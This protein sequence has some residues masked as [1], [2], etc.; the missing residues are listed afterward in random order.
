MKMQPL[1]LTVHARL[2]PCRQAVAAAPG[3]GIPHVPELAEPLHP[4]APVR[5]LLGHPPFGAL[6]A[7]LLTTTGVPKCSLPSAARPALPSHHHPKDDSYE[8]LAAFHHHLYSYP[9]AG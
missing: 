7:R 8:A 2:P 1:D 4:P 5:P 9:L 6:E 3:A